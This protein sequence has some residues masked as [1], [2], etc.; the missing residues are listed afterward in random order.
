MS[1]SLVSVLQAVIDRHRVPRFSRPMK[2]RTCSLFLVFVPLALI[3][4][5]WRVGVLGQPFFDTDAFGIV[6][7]VMAFLANLQFFFFFF[8]AM[9]HTTGH[10]NRAADISEEYNRLLVPVFDDTS[11]KVAVLALTPENVR[12]W[13][14]G[15]QA[16]LLYG[17]VYWLR[18]SWSTAFTAILESVLLAIVLVQLLLSLLQGNPMRI[19][20]FV[21]TVCLQVLIMSGGFSFV[22][23]AGIGTM[24]RR[25]DYRTRVLRRGSELSLGT[26]LGPDDKTN[27]D[28]VVAELRNLAWVLESEMESHKVRMLG[29]PLNSRMLESLFGGVMAIGLVCY[30]M[31]SAAEGG[32]AVGR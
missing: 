26:A 24:R 23:L 3:P 13:E 31:V 30:Q 12:V 1:R 21:I 18:L 14:R 29:L 5:F 15:R 16:L 32:M 19:T 27:A 28:A 4:S 6:A 9:F 22:V 17:H 20:G 10:M 8:W 25:R 2:T 11:E 7:C